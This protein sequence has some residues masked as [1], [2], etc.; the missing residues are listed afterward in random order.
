MAIEKLEAT[1]DAV[2]TRTM[3]M[4]FAWDW[5]AGVA[6][7]GI[8]EAH[9]VTEKKEYVDFLVHWVDDYIARGI[10]SFTVNS[11]SIGHTVLY[12]YQV[13]GEEKYLSLA[14]EMAEYLRKDAVRFGNGVF[15]HTVSQNYSFPE[16][17]WADTLFMAAF[18]LIRI[19]T[20]L[21][22]DDYIKDSLNQYY[23]HEEFLQDS[24]TDLYFHGWDNINKN[25]MSSIHWARANAWAAYTMAGALRL[26]SVTNPS[27]MRIEGSLRDQIAALTRKQ[28]DAG[29][30]HT[31]VD[32]PES[33]EEI[34]ASAGIAAAIIGYEGTLGQ[35]IYRKAIDRATEGLL[36]NVS[37][38]GRVMNVSA[39]TAVMNDASGYREVPRKRIQGW[40]QGL[41]LAFLSEILTIEKKER[42]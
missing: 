9:R 38:E 5:S 3:N 23:W 19:G 30:W 15:Q 27:F 36:A 16:Q 21:K 14:T 12:L 24:V 26:L 41:M 18:F 20:I 28:S 11:V 17:A 4:D 32:D 13:T 22:N 10:P 2:V 1:I 8:C 33:Y 35:T 31:I 34:S 7:Y 37:P 6:F 29:L 42:K 25:N 40:G 39:G